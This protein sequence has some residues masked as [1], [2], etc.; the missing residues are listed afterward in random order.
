MKWYCE[1]TN[2]KMTIQELSEK[3]YEREPEFQKRRGTYEGVPVYDTLSKAIKSLGGYSHEVTL[4]NG[5]TIIPQKE[6]YNL[7]VCAYVGTVY[8][9]IMD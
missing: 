5:K 4:P 3:A 8:C 9:E 2:G 1:F 7:P 6:N